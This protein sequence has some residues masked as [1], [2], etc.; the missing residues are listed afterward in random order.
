[1]GDIKRDNLRTDHLA[2][3]K[4]LVVRVELLRFKDSLFLDDPGFVCSLCRK[5]FPV[6]SFQTEEELLRY[7]MDDILE[8]DFC[9]QMIMEDDG[10]LRLFEDRDFVKRGKWEV[11]LHRRCLG[12][13]F[14]VGSEI[15]LRPD[16][17]IEWRD[18]VE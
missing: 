7:G 9:A 10:Q 12:Q 18:W 6:G 4:Q 17:Q 3:V 11:R 13:L 5:P 2:R 14:D 1:M 16:V 8:G 15:I